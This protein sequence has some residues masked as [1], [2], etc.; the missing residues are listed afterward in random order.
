MKTHDEPNPLACATLSKGRIIA[1]G[2]NRERRGVPV[3]K[4]LAGKGVSQG[5]TG[6]CIRKTRLQAD[7]SHSAK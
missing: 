3:K 7:G 6:D 4:M 2:T 5:D 1:T